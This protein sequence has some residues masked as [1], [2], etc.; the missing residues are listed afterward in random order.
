[1]EYYSAI[2]KEWNLAICN[3][4]DRPRGCYV[5]WNKSEKDK[6]CIF[7]SYVESK[8]QNKWTNITKQN[9]TH[10]YREQITGCQRGGRWGMNKID[11]GVKR[12]KLPVKK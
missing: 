3:N 9:Q 10:R 5:K 1:M 6:Y 7:H 2:K 12:Y 4:M 8:K 11:E